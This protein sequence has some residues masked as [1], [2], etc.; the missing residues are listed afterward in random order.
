MKRREEGGGEAAGVKGGE[1]RE[2]TWT[3]GR[4]AS[5]P[6]AP[7]LLEIG[8]KAQTPQLVPPVTCARLHVKEAEPEMS[9]GGT[10][11]AG[12]TGWGH[13]DVPG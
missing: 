6:L 7:S 5:G 13:L 10:A 2:D 4:L 3:D 1:A 11:E 9:W 8:A 12:E